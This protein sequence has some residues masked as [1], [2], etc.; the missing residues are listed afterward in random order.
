MKLKDIVRMVFTDYESIRQ[1]QKKDDDI[2]PCSVYTIT[3]CY[4]SDEETWIT[5]P[6]DHPIIDYLGDLEIY[7]FNPDKDTL[8]CWVKI[9]DWY[10]EETLDNHWEQDFKTFKTIK[11]CI[12]LLSTDGKG[13]KQQVKEKLEELIK[14][15]KD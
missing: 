13:T 6:A 11:Q 15:A 2:R 12:D 8:Q 7:A 4:M 10:K 1:S 14:D 5:I 9:E 3:L